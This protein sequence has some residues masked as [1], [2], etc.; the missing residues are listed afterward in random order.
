VDEQTARVWIAAFGVLGTLLGAVLGFAGSFLIE[1]GRRRREERHRFSDVRRSLYVRL[2][3]GADAIERVATSEMLHLRMP[4]APFNVPTMPDFDEAIGFTTSEI[5]LVSTARV[6]KSAS[7]LMSASIGMH[8]YSLSILG[9]DLGPSVSEFPG[10][11]E[12][13][14]KARHAFREAVRAE[15]LEESTKGGAQGVWR[16]WRTR[17]DPPIVSPYQEILDNLG[18]VKKP[19]GDDPDT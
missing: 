11:H 18:T 10:R 3:A 5:S 1:R 19:S 12:A 17:E 15:L 16:R 14:L 2:L 7:G 4:T 13:F 8:E 6:V 9:E